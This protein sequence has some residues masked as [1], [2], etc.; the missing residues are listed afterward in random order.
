[1]SFLI[2]YQTR[3][4]RRSTSKG[5]SASAVYLP[6]SSEM[7]MRR[8]SCAEKG[9]IFTGQYGDAADL[10]V[11]VAVQLLSSST[12]GTVLSIFNPSDKMGKFSRSLLWFYGTTTLYHASS[13]QFVNAQANDTSWHRYIRAPA[14]STVKPKAVLDEYTSGEVV[15]AE[16]LVT[17]GNTTLLIRSGAG[18]AIPTVVL[19]FGQNVV[20]LLEIDFA[21]STNASDGFPG[22]KLSFSESLEFLGNRSDF[23]RSDNAGQ[24]GDVGAP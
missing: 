19:D 21:S 14:N 10:T 18:A 20:G 6:C 13:N 11:D 5:G 12:C 8:N 2:R 1:M 22:L 3:A 7:S 15:N 17:G 4:A 9:G 16:S 24:G 23:T